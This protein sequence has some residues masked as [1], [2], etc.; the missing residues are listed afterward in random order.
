VIRKALP[1][2][3]FPV[4][5]TIALVIALVAVPGRSELALRIFLLVLAAFALLHLVA[6][7]RHAFPAA[8]PS[9]FERALRRREP[10]QDRLPELAKLEREVALGGSTA[11]DLHYR[12]RPPVRR[13]AGELLAARRGIDLDTEPEAARR[14]LGDEAWELVRP[15]REPPQNRYAPGIETAALATVV[16]SLEAL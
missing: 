16:T 6:A 3:Q 14:L 9:P 8:G 10:R 1:L 4:L 5:L 12:L 15:D 11:F 13:I 2:V 7:V